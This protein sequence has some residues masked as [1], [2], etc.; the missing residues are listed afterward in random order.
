MSRHTLLRVLAGTVL[1]LVA[2]GAVFA[3]SEGRVWRL[4]HLAQV[5]EATETTRG[6]MLPELAEL[7]FVEGNNLVLDARFGTPE[8]LPAL[9]RAL[10][11]TAPDAI[12]AIGGNAAHAAAAA[13]RTLPIVSYGPDLV[14]FGLAASQ[15]RPGGNVT[16]VVILA[17]E[18]DGKRLD[19]LLE[20]VPR[21]TRL[22]VLLRPPNRQIG[23]RLM[24][25]IA[26]QRAVELLVFE[27]T[28]DG[29]RAVFDQML[30]SRAQGLAIG[31][32][33]GLYRDR[34]DLA[35]L[36]LARGLPTMCQWAEMAHAGCLVSYGPNRAA[37]RRRLAH[38]VARIFRG[39]APGELPIEAPTHFELTVNLK[40][41]RALGIELPPSLLARAD[42]VIE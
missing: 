26:A 33:P 1:A 19:L 5:E 40:T 6:Q 8:Q 12:V 28:P 42:E 3:Q 23:E 29:Y 27:A 11:A 34:N 39:A 22:A 7:G 21:A 38:Y 41:A 30:G 2:P 10:V 20:A 18:L 31:A 13:T 35:A 14:A 25:D 16:G 4:A 15:V 32:D 36:A 24:R 9:A 17:A 37:L